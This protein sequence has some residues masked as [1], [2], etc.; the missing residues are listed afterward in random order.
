LLNISSKKS[1]NT[2]GTI[3]NLKFK[4]PKNMGQALT[5]KDHREGGSDSTSLIGFQSP[6]GRKWVEAELKIHTELPAAAP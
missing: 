6:L 1:S 2:L 3:L 4:A 5:L